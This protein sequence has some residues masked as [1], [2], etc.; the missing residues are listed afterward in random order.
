[1]RNVEEFERALDYPWDKWT[2]FLHHAQRQL[3]DR[4]YQKDPRGLPV[5]PERARPSLL[6]TGPLVSFANTRTPSAAHRVAQT[7][8]K[9]IALLGT[10]P[11]RGQLRPNYS[12]RIVR[13]N[14][15][16]RYSHDY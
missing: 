6:C 2:V 3:V 16:R 12:S 14:Q 7:I 5:R 15:R 9:A 11:N 8:Y 4:D 13:D 1:M 10:M